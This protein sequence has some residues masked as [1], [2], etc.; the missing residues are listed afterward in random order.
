MGRGGADCRTADQLWPLRQREGCCSGCGQVRTAAALYAIEG[1][2]ADNLAV[3]VYVARSPVRPAM[4]LSVY[5]LVVCR[6]IRRLFHRRINKIHLG[7]RCRVL[8]LN[9]GAACARLQV[10]LTPAQKIQ[11]QRRTLEAWQAKQQSASKRRQFG[12]GSSRH[13]GVSKEGKGST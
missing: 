12:K 9:E 13:I 3:S 5:V 6:L 4:R 7:P 8:Y 1:V 2:V 11:L 10:G